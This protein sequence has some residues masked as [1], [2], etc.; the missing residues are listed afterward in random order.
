MSVS[1]PP[2]VASAYDSDTVVVMLTKSTF[3]VFSDSHIF[4]SV[5]I[6]SDLASYAVV[7]AKLLLKF[8]LRQ[9]QTHFMQSNEIMNRSQLERQLL[10]IHAKHSTS[11]VVDNQRDHVFVC[12]WA[13]HVCMSFVNFRI[14]VNGFCRWARIYPIVYH[15][16]ACVSCMWNIPQEQLVRYQNNGLALHAKFHLCTSSKGAFR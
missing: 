8:I 12:V 9:I 15:V 11:A 2:S 6:G 13:V 3:A 16:C 7:Q 10:G 4:Y 1:S 5:K 14:F